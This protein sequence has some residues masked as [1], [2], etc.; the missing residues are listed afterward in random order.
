M[1]RLIPPERQ[2]GGASA[3]R[4]RVSSTP[5]STLRSVPEI[6]SLRRSPVCA[7]APS[8]F[9]RTHWRARWAEARHVT[10]TSTRSHV[11]ADK[12]HRAAFAPESL[13]IC[14]VHVAHSHPCPGMQASNLCESIINTSAE[15]LT[16][17]NCSSS[18]VGPA[19]SR[20][21][22]LFD[23]ESS[24]SSVCTRGPGTYK[25]GRHH[26]TD[27]WNSLLVTML[28]Q[29]PPPAARTCCVGSRQITRPRRHGRG[30]PPARTTQDE[31]AKVQQ[32]HAHASCS[33]LAACIPAILE[34]YASAGP[35][36]GPCVPASRTPQHTRSAHAPHTHTTSTQ[37][38]HPETA[39]PPRKGANCST[40]LAS[41]RSQKRHPAAWQHLP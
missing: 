5:P 31:R 24:G 35:G 10:A 26:T 6:H 17:A 40:A 8:A 39:P 25:D 27:H 36:H 2:R 18:A 22:M 37:Q 23:T 13:A 1:P 32:G 38:R 34:N 41:T 4:E 30:T 14:V 19:D 33:L 20:A 3:W 21:C 9:Q 11:R 29:A 16:E 12:T 28:T 15:A 7:S